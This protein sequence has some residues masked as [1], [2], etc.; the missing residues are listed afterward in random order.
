MRSMAAREGP[1]I[2]CGSG[3]RVSCEGPGSCV[4]PSQLGESEARPPGLALVEHD[5]TADS[6]S[7]LAAFSGT[8]FTLL[9]EATTPPPIGSATISFFIDE[10]VSFHA[11][12]LGGLSPMQAHQ[13]TIF[14]NTPKVLFLYVLY[15]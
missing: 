14:I 6:S 13:N 3:E 7:A 15:Y 10:V 2:A 5:A 12:F 4:E 9:D 1:H 8:M 11:V